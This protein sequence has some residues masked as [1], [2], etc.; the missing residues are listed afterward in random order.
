MAS[1]GKGNDQQN[2]RF[3]YSYHKR[4]WGKSKNCNETSAE[5]EQCLLLPSAYTLG[6]GQATYG[7][8][9]HRGHLD[10][11]GCQVFPYLDTQTVNTT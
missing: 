6:V 2:D 7:F 5:N 4:S 1:L 8:V 11:K 9:K 10:D 3:G